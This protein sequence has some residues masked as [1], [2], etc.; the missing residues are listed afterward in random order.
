MGG[1]MQELIGKVEQWAIDKGID[2]AENW[3][4]QF[5]KIVE[6]VMEYK[7]ELKLSEHDT[8][9]NLMDEMTEMGD[10]LVTL[11]IMAQQRGY[12]LKQCLEL[13]YDKIKDRKGEVIDGNFVKAEDI[14]KIRKTSEDI[15]KL[16]CSLGG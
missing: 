14:G 16:E 11:T 13:A 10:I 15:G 12:E 8:A 1:I 4:P 3:K 2:T 6:E 9:A 7:E 5:K